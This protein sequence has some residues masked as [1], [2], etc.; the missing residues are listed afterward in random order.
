MYSQE[1]KPTLFAIGGLSGSGKSHLA[2]LG[3]GPQ[4][5]IIIRS[6]ATRKRIAPNHPDLEQYGR[7]MHI[8]TYNAMFDAA[9]I[10]LKAG[11]PV[12]LDATFLHPG[13]RKQVSELANECSVSL[14]FYW[15]DIDPETLKSNICHRQQS[16]HDISDADLDVLIRQLIEYRCPEEDCIDFLK[17]SDTFPVISFVN[18]N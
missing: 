16:G 3:C 6:D 4:R 14:H 8:H 17:S 1:A 12:I 10:A 15:L 9:R 2:L 18:P 5:A 11:F 7:D 13:S